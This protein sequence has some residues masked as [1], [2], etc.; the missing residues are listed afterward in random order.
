M[1]V[2]NLK[3][4]CDRRPTVQKCPVTI[5]PTILPPTVVLCAVSVQTVQCTTLPS[6]AIFSPFVAM[7]TE[8]PDDS[9]GK[10]YLT[11]VNLY[12]FILQVPL[13]VD[14]VTYYIC[15]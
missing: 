7:V 6:L 2:K 11:N 9:I 14:I 8:E 15:A 5:Q 4:S 1:V 3:L 13:S 12:P 10:L